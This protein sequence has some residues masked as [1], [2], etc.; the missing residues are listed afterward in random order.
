VIVLL[1]ELTEHPIGGEMEHEPGKDEFYFA[2]VT[3]NGEWHQLV[4]RVIGRL[5]R[6]GD[7]FELPGAEF[8]A[9]T[10]DQGVNIA[11]GR[12]NLL[13]L[14][15]PP[16]GIPEP[17]FKWFDLLSQSERGIAFPIHS[18]ANPVDI[19][20]RAL[21]V[22]PSTAMRIELWEGGDSFRTQVYR[23]AYDCLMRRRIGDPDLPVR[24][25]VVPFCPVCNAYITEAIMGSL[26]A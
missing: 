21:P 24:T 7:E 5:L 20:D 17:E 6:L 13:Y 12:P 10:E 14:P 8:Q 9:P 19:P 16:E 1:P 26:S 18:H 11:I 23:S 2:A 22:A 15:E 3:K 25:A 4:A